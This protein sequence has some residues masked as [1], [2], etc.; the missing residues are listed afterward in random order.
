MSLP[1]IPIRSSPLNILQSFPAL[2][3]VAFAFLKKFLGAVS[4]IIGRNN[5]VWMLNEIKIR[6][7]SYLFSLIN[8]SKAN[9]SCLSFSRSRPV[10]SGG[11]SSINILFCAVAF[12]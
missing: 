5:T 6:Y 3:H 8:F 12:L 9:T 10:L 1:T 11:K 2:G 4:Q 7:A